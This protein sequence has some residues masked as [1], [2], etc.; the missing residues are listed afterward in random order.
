MLAG[1]SLV[2]IIV[3]A[4]LLAPWLGLQ[5]PIAQN[6]GERLAPPSVSH[7]L[8]TDAFGRDVF[9][10]V[11]YAARIDVPLAVLG[12]LL[13]A[14]VGTALGTLAAVGGRAADYVIMRVGELAQAF[15]AYIFFIVAAFVV[16]PGVSTFLAA[17]LLVTWVSYAR[18]VR[19]QTLVTREADFM[20]AAHTSGIARWRVVVRHLV[21]NAIPQAVVYLASDVVF[22]LV[23]LSSLSYL[24]LGIAEP[25]P[26]WGNMIAAGQPYLRS[27]WW[28]S[29]VPGIMIVLVGIAF[30][31]LSEGLDDVR[32]IE[33]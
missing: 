26:E 33:R 8:G 7:L 15:P 13:P 20:K 19:A 22:A 2:L 32:R 27:A 28:L 25:T 6:L 12:A 24:G 10:R 31:L 21:P 5:D 14:L 1:G 9:S 30:V 18:I 16:G 4:G 11:V 29:T 23:A 17:A 3:G